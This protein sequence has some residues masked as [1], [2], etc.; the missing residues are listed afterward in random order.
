MVICLKAP[1]LLIVIN[2]YITTKREKIY[3]IKKLLVRGPSPATAQVCP[4]SQ[5]NR[6]E[7]AQED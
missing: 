7:Q 3:A 2:T 5:T 4:S 6:Q 1:F